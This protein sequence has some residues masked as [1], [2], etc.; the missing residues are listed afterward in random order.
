[1]GEV[2]DLRAVA[3]TEREIETEE[4]AALCC[5]LFSLPPCGRHCWGIPCL[6][7]VP[8]PL[9][10]HY[11]SS[12]NSSSNNGC[13]S[14]SNSRSCYVRLYRDPSGTAGASRPSV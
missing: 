3:A 1:M 6:R 9:L 4:V 8:I 13:S 12:S 10:L 14:S 2:K 5:L 7:A 11:M